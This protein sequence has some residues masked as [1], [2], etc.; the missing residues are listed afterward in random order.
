MPASVAQ[1]ATP[2]FNNAASA[3]ISIALSGTVAGNTLD[4]FVGANDAGGGLTLVSTVDT[5]GNPWWWRHS[6]LFSFIR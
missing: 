4:A 2:T 3:T 6:W 5:Q 1:E